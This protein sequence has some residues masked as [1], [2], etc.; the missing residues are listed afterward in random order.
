MLALPRTDKKHMGG[1]GRGRGRRSRASVGRED[2]AFASIG[3]G[4]GPIGRPT[5][6]TGAKAAAA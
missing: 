2:R 5:H 6:R 1:R 3:K 4:F